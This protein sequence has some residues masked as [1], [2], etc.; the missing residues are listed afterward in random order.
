MQY[1]ELEQPSVFWGPVF[2]LTTLSAA[3]PRSN[4]HTVVISAAVVWTAFLCETSATGAATGGPRGLCE[5]HQLF[6]EWSA[7]G[8][9]Q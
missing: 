3:Q 1:Y 8:V 6:A 2:P 7:A 9:R 5:L 4:S